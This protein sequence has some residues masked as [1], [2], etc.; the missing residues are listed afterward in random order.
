[1]LIRRDTFKYF[2]DPFEI[3]DG[4]CYYNWMIGEYGEYIEQVSGE[5]IEKVHC[6]DGLFVRGIKKIVK[7]FVKV[8]SR[9]YMKLKKIWY[10]IRW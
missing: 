9:L 3:H 4:F 8:D 7:S 10:A 5:H 2:D 1:M 6:R